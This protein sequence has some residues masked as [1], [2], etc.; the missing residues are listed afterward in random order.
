MKATGIVR[1]IGNLGRF[2]LP[3]ELRKLIDVDEGD[4][5]EVFAQEDS[6]VL[7]KYEPF[8]FFCGNKNVQELVIYNGHR[9]CR[10][11]IEKLQ[12]LAK[13]EKNG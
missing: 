5:L 4:A 11:C 2:V 12:T 1:K 6:L 10:D 8:C 3:I 13:E 9:I 7:R